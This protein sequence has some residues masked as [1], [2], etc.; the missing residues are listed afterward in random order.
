MVSS[1][2]NRSVFQVF[3]H[4]SKIRTWFLSELDWFFFGLLDR[5]FLTDTGP[6][7]NRDGFS[8]FGLVSLT[9]FG[10]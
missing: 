5:A 3:W 4:F 1:A 7:N 2:M 10:F 8:G 9:D 6:D